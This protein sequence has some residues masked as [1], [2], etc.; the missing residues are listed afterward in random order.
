MLEWRGAFIAWI[1]RRLEVPVR[2]IAR[3]TAQKCDVPMGTRSIAI[4]YV[5]N[6][7]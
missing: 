4:Q 3:D 2:S 1:D 6:G 5:A 7:F